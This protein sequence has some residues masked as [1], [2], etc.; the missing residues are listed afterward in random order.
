MKQT[1]K[2]IKAALKKLRETVET[3]SDP[4]VTRTAQAMETAIRWAT[5]ETVG[6]PKP[7][8][9]AEEMAQCLKNDLKPQ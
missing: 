7:H 9:E 6:W 3:N 8:K 4:Y 2:K 5:E 1:P